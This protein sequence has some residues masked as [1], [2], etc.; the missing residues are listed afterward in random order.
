MQAIADAAFAR[1][2]R[3]DDFGTG[4]RAPPPRLW[5]YCRTRYGGIEPFPQIL[6]LGHAALQR[7]I[8]IS[9]GT[10]EMD[11]P[12]VVAALAHGFWFHGH[13]E[14]VAFGKFTVAQRF[15]DTDVRAVVDG[16]RHREIKAGEG[17][18]F[19]GHAVI[20]R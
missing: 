1:G 16:Q 7:Q 2:V 10:D 13:F 15:R 17:I 3:H 18:G 5:R 9:D 20:L 12:R 8:A 6:I 11:L 14:T 4:Q 19:V